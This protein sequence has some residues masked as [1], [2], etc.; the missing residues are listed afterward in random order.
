MSFVGGVR[1]AMISLASLEDVLGCDSRLTDAL[2]R[3]GWN[4][5]RLTT[6]KDD[7]D[8]EMIELLMLNVQDS[9]DDGCKVHVSSWKELS[10]LRRLDGLLRDASAAAI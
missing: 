1:C 9:V 4:V 8:G 2:T 10:P 5:A 3:L 6:L 7:D